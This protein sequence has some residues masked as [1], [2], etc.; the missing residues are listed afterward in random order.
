MKTNTALR[1]LDQSMHPS[2]PVKSVQH[3]PFSRKTPAWKNDPIRKVRKELRDECRLLRNTAKALIL[4]GLFAE[5]LM[6]LASEWVGTAFG[7]D[8]RIGLFAVGFLFG[9]GNLFASVILF[10]VAGV[11]T[12]CCRELPKGV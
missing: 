3:K 7:M 1:L 9:L 12:D 10:S 4:L 6:F 5:F 2:D 11:I 8:G